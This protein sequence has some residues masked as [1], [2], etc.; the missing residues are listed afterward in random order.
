[1]GQR[2]RDQNTRKMPLMLTVQLC[3]GK[4]AG[5]DVSLLKKVRKVAMRGIQAARKRLLHTCCAL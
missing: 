5:S 3:G 1:M 4:R 2:L